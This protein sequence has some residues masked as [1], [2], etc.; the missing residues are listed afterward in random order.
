MS[1]HG[2]EDAGLVERLRAQLEQMTAERD[3]LQQ[4]LDARAELDQVLMQAA[5]APAA[6]G[7]GPI[8]RV[9]GPRAGGHRAPKGH[10][11][12]K[13]KRHLWIVPAFIA[14]AV[15]F[16][17]RGLT[18]HRVLSVGLAAMVGVPAVTAVS[19]H[20]AQLLPGVS[21]LPSRPPGWGTTGT[22][23]PLPV[24]SMLAVT[25]PRTAVARSR[26]LVP[27]APPCPAPSPSPS[28]SQSMP[29]PTPSDPQ[30]SP[31][32]P[33]WVPQPSYPGGGGYERHRDWRRQSHGWQ[34][35]DPAPSGTAST[36]APESSTP[37]APATGTPTD[38][39]ADATAPAPSST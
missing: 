29:S 22:P 34:S 32:L 13:E 17:L 16:G 15:R 33:S 7:T 20:G 12:P 6:D 27:L 36:A 11:I 23:V 31:A 25:R 24:A 10:R 28:P 19:T 21:A 37:A 4:H 3:R 9:Q 2:K 1:R 38:L 18:H 39:P 35:S 30:P 14:G 8:A 26:P 5:A